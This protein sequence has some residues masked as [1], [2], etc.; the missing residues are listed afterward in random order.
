MANVAFI[1]PL[2]GGWEI[3]DATDTESI[4]TVYSSAEDA[5]IM[6]EALNKAY[7]KR[8]EGGK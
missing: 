7:E 8:A 6:C 2:D 1:E 4:A 3:M 5:E